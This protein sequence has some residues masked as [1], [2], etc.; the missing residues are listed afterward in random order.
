MDTFFPNIADL[1]KNQYLVYEIYINHMTKVMTMSGSWDFW[2]NLHFPLLLLYAAGDML[3]GNL[4]QKLKSEW[5]GLLSSF[6][7]QRL[8]DHSLFGKI[9]WAC[10]LKSKESSFLGV[11]HYILGNK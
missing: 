8:Q 1:I 4:S 5:K 3:G 7:K 11:L 2:M 10:T 6:K 9:A